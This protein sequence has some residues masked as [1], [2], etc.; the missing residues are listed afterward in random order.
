M[1]FFLFCSIAFPVFFLDPWGWWGSTFP[2]LTKVLCVRLSQLCRDCCLLP[3]PWGGGS[4]GWL[5]VRSFFLLSRH[6]QAVSYENCMVATWEITLGFDPIA[7]IERF[8][9]WQV[10]GKTLLGTGCGASVPL[11]VSGIFRSSVYS[12]DPA[13]QCFMRAEKRL[14]IGDRRSFPTDRRLYGWER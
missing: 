3:V 13:Q 1:L 14:G 6:I 8:T 11:L 10:A 12:R 7:V 2:G 4:R 5:I 9:Q